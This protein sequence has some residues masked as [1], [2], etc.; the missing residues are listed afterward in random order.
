MNSLIT[1]TPFQ[2]LTPFLCWIGSHTFLL[3]SLDPSSDLDLVH[4]WACMP[5]AREFWGMSLHPKA[6]QAW[7]NMVLRGPGAH[8]YLGLL[9]GRPVCQLEVYDPRGL[10]IGMKYPVMAGDLGIH[11]LMGPDRRILPGLSGKV[12]RSVLEFLFSFPGV[13]RIIAEPDSRNRA[14]HL[15]ARQAGFRYWD[16][17]SLKDKE[18]RLYGCSRTEFFPNSTPEGN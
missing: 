13:R 1:R 3:R 2:P 8:A 17:V 11:L 5:H 6:F 9:E 16:T 10:E 14:A 15:V 12:L 7:Y 18:A 4:S